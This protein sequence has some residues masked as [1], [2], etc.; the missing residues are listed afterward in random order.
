MLEEKLLNRGIRNDRFI[1][2]VPRAP[3]QN[4][5]HY[6]NYYYP[7]SMG[8]GDDIM[9]GARG[10]GNFGYRQ[11]PPAHS[12][13]RNR[14]APSP[15]LANDSRLDQSASDDDLGGMNR[16]RGPMIRGMGQ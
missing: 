8:V 16:D 2:A 12:A 15:F 10:G 3:P 9:D 4:A 6:P 5:M 11:A 14:R 7:P 1:N 13:D